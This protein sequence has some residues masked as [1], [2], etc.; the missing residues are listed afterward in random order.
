MY[1]SKCQSPLLGYGVLDGSGF[2]MASLTGGGHTID[3]QQFPSN[4]ASRSPEG[5][6]Y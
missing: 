5:T 6:H 3:A 2:E 1:L 4:L